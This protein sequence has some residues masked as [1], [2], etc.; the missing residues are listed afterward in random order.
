MPVRGVRGAVQAAANSPEAI[1]SATRQLLMAMVEANRIAVEQIIS[2]FFTTTVDLN[3]GY[4]AAAARQLGWSDVPLLGAQEVE[5]PGS[6]PRVIR[7]LMHI[8]TGKPRAE[9][10]HSYLGSTVTLRPDLHE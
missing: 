3:A 1:D 4:P 6:I 7:V 9:I 2:I 10:H 5:V 8:D